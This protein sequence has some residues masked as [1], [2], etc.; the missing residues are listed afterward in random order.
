MKMF[1]KIVSVA[2]FLVIGSGAGLAVPFGKQLKPKVLKSLLEKSAK[3]PKVKASGNC[4]DFS[5]KWVGVCRDESGDDVDDAMRIDQYECEDISIDDDLIHIG[6][7]KTESE[8]SSRNMLNI[9]IFPQWNAAR[10]S[11]QFRMNLV[12]REYDFDLFFTGIVRA[13]MVKFGDQLILRSNGETEV[14]FDGRTE[15]Y[16]YW[17]ECTYEQTK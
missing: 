13:S 10:N 8:S 7:G 15:T 17:S 12:G 11:V 14:D 5:G 9:S 4:T 3:S 16:Q 1:L 2:A 6:G